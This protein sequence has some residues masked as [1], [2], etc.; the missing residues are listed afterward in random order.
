[1]K[2]W[3][4]VAIVGVGLIGGSIGLALQ[5]RGLASTVVGI[6]RRE[7]SLSRAMRHGVVTETTTQI[8]LGVANAELVVVC[9]PVGTVVESV[10][11]IVKHSPAATLVTDAGSTKLEIVRQL[12]VSLP[13]PA[14]FIGSH[15][16]AGS[17]KTGPEN[18]RADLFEDRVTVLTPTER[19]AP[20]QIA[21][22]EQFWTALGCS[23]MQMSPS[24]HDQAVAMTSHVTHVIAAAL[25]AATAD[26]ELP[27]VGSGWKDTTRIAA[28]DPELWRQILFSNRDQVLKSLGKFE[29]VLAKFRTAMERDDQARIVQLLDSGKQTRDSMGN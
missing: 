19:S 24:A 18:A 28:G 29:K 16:L 26:E 22:L 15:P 7:S 23:V 27:L 12:A 9:T 20:N 3:D 6:G 1:M 11:R 8:E 10:E 5:Q 2:K 21:R 4:T 25:A 14:V 13:D 17:E